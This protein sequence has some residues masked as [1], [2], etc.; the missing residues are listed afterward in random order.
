MP[1]TVALEGLCDSCAKVGKMYVPGLMPGDVL[2]CCL[3]G[4]VSARG[5]DL[6]TV[7]L[8]LSQCDEVETLVSS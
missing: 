7:G 6:E 3:C 1:V 4:D 2:I 5:A 8:T